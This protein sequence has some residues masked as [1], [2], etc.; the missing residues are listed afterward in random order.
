M[1][2]ARQ[3]GLFGLGS[4][5]NSVAIRSL[6]PLPTRRDAQALV[7]APPLMAA[8]REVLCFEGWTV[9][10]LHL[11]GRAR[12]CLLFARK[13]PAVLRP[14]STKCVVGGCTSCATCVARAK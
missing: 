8:H 13:P 6:L 1:A 3:G 5:G 9:R 4:E 10:C 7:P 2:K 14:P 12:L 11:G